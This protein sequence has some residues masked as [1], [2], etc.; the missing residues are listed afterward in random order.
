MS[1]IAVL[2]EE[3]DTMVDGVIGR[4]AGRGEHGDDH[5][6]VGD[7]ITWSVVVS[8]GGRSGGGEEGHDGEE[9]L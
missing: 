1:N 8:G 9:L 7:S 4:R 3:G 5:V 2:G 6:T